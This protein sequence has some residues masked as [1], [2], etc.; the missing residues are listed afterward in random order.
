MTGE[1]ASGEDNPL[2]HA[3]HDP[4][5]AYDVQ[6]TGVGRVVHVGRQPGGRWRGKRRALMTGVAAAMVIACAGIVVGS[7]FLLTALNPPHRVAQATTTEAA[8]SIA[9]IAHQAPKVVRSTPTAPPPTPV[10][11]APGATPPPPPPGP[12]PIGGVPAIGGQ[13]ILVSLSQQWLWAYNYGTLL[14]DTPVTSGMPQLATPDGVFHVQYKEYDVTFY[15]P[16]PIGS[17]YYYSPEHVDFAMYFA[18]YGY[19]V[20]DAPWRHEFGP[21]TNYPHTDPDGTQETGSHGCVNVPY[22]AGAW[23]YN[24]AYNGATVD[25]YGTAPTGPAATPTPQPTAPATATPTQPTAPTPTTTP[26][27]DTPTPTPSPTATP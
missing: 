6:D 12:A 24:W 16:W 3:P 11:P 19:Y 17:P 8:T 20:H 7:S 21:G 22:N 14:Y 10:P 25:I 13:L 4:D 2:D 27:A 1:N 15:S 23:L 18:D 5:T 26:I 9:T